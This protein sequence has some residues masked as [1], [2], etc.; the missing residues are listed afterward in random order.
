[1]KKKLI[2]FFYRC[3]HFVLRH[4]AA[5]DIII[6]NKLSQLT[7]DEGKSSIELLTGFKSRDVFFTPI[8]I[9]THAG[10]GMGGLPYLNCTVGLGY[11]YSAGNRVFEFDVQKTVDD[12]FVLSHTSV[13]ISAVEFQAQRIDYRFLPMP[14]NEV[15]DFVTEHK[16]VK[17]VFDCKFDNPGVFAQYIKNYVVYDDALQRIVL[18]VIREQDIIDMKAVY[19]FKLLYVCMMEADYTQ[20]A[21]C[22]LKYKIGA[23]SISTKA[24]EE[25]RGWDVFIKSNICIFAYTVNKVSDF[26]NLKSQGITGIFSDF[27]FEKDIK[28]I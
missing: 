18:Q 26:Y 19:D 4:F 20:I 11:Y 2:V 8:Q 22:C 1:M 27:I 16:D 6:E 14:I 7:A 5:A 3:L 28:E 23:V 21:N 24:L 17:V 12:E 15:L 9:I 25:R 10:G 13:N